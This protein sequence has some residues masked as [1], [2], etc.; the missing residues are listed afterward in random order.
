MPRGVVAIFTPSGRLVA[1]SEDPDL[2][3]E[4]AEVLLDELPSVAE[5]PDDQH[6]LD[7]RRQVLVRLAAAGG[8]E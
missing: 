1:H 7:A 5:D 4:V 8:G 2:A 6:L 3:R